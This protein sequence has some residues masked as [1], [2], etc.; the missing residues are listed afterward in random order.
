M[1]TLHAEVVRKAIPFDDF[2]QIAQAKTA[3]I[4]L[5]DQKIKFVKEHLEAFRNFLMLMQQQ[6]LEF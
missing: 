4:K 1:A 5:A 2:A 3:Q 6:G